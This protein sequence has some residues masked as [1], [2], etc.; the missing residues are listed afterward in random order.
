MFTFEDSMLKYGVTLYNGDFSDGTGNLLLFSKFIKNVLS[1]EHARLLSQGHLKYPMEIKIP[2][3]TDALLRGDFEP[4]RIITIKE[5]ILFD[6]TPIWF[7]SSLNGVYARFGN[8]NGDS[9]DPS[10]YCFSEQA[11]HG[12]LGGIT[13]FGKS[14]LLN[15]LIFGMCFEYAPWEINITVLDAKA[16]DGKRFGFTDIPHIGMV[17][18]TFDS[19]Y[20]LSVLEQKIT[21]M[22][23]RLAI[24]SRAGSAANIMDFRKITGLCLPRE[25]VIFDELQAALSSAG[26][27]LPKFIK[28]IDEYARLGRAAGYHLFISSQGVSKELSKEL[29]DQFEI[30]CCLG[31]SPEVSEKILGNDGAK[32]IK[33]KGILYVNL[34]PNGKKREDNKEIK[35]PF[36]PSS[37]TED[38]FTPQAAFLAE[39]GKRFD[40]NRP[41][42]FYDETDL[43]YEV[44]QKG[45]ESKPTYDEFLATFKRDKNRICLGE[46]AVVV[47]TPEK[48][49]DIKFTGTDIE[50]LAVVNSS[51]TELV[52][53]AR[54]LK[55]NIAGT[56]CLNIVYAVNSELSKAIGFNGFANQVFNLESVD[57]MQYNALFNS[58]N[59]RK[60]MLRVDEREVSVNCHFSQASAD[61]LKIF[62]KDRPDIYNSKVMC[63]RVF[64]LRTL[65]EGENRDY[66]VFPD[67]IKFTPAEL[68]EI[69]E[70][71]Y[72]PASRFH[73]A[74]DKQIA[75]IIRIYT[76]MGAVNK[77]I[78]ADDFS[79]IYYW[80]VGLDR[81]RG[82]GRDP[83][84]KA[85][86]NLKNAL[87]DLYKVN[88]RCIIVTADFESD[89]KAVFRAVRY[90]I[91][92]NSDAK[93][94]AL[95]D[96]GDYYPSSVLKQLG[97]LSDK[98]NK[99]SIK[100]KKMFLDGEMLGS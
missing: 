48:I 50:N 47:T 58:L 55:H 32:N 59:T 67:G 42:D 17:G 89:V 74:V 82:I 51:S 5:P 46:P 92:S 2:K 83:K 81:L 69:E 10:K 84:S 30:R 77:L 62:F 3:S 43:I 39:L 66:Y 25:I 68:K 20:M 4:A 63:A 38:E 72:E 37:G 54:M 76:N 56:N 33:K 21:D 36:Q 29:L 98:V 12:S 75:Q 94:Q 40:F 80:I 87:Y 71:G 79:T 96:L 9:R 61:Y 11:K 97:V 100:F 49:I 53:F 60:L 35:V 52:R 22:R 14:V 93:Q 65:L 73:F 23:T 70:L 7:A 41:M 91:T 34:N 8:I 57:D 19:D 95:L 16:S 27:N 88:I 28:A 99:T 45:S 90:I 85:I 1:R 15:V 24:I 44:K 78:C 86:D 26:K 31:A 18:A 13:G 64:Y 6:D